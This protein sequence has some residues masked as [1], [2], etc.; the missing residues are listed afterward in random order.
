MRTR[1]MRWNDAWTLCE[2][3]YRERA[4]SGWKMHEVV[5]LN[6]FDFFDQKLNLLPDDDDADE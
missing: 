5:F 2:W 3:N 6:E 1:T 4:V